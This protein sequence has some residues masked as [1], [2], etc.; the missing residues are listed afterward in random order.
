[1][2]HFAECSFALRHKAFNPVFLENAKDIARF[3]YGAI[4]DTESGTIHS[5]IIPQEYLEIRGYRFYFC[6]RYLMP[7]GSA[8]LFCIV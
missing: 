1:M 8:E 7:I 4:T 2:K 5:Q 6:K 3:D